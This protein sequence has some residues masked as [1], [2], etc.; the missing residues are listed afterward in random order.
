MPR[1]R[2]G[3][4]GATTLATTLALT[5]VFAGCKDGGT[6]IV[7]APAPAPAPAPAAPTVTAISPSRGP[8]AGGTRVEITGTGL[9]GATSIMIGDAPLANVVVQSATTIVGDTASTRTVSKVMVEVTT[10]NGVGSLADAFEYRLGLTARP[11]AVVVG[12]PAVAL[13]VGDAD[14]DA[15]PDLFVTSR[16]GRVEVLHGDGAGGIAAVTTVALAGHDTFGL[17][18]GDLDGDGDDD[19]VVTD[20]ANHQVLVVHGDGVGGFALAA[21]V[22]GG[23]SS[24]FLGLVAAAA[25]IVTGCGG[26]SSNSS[27]GGSTSTAAA[28]TSAAPTATTSSAAA[29]TVAALVVDATV[30][31]SGPSDPTWY[32]RTDDPGTPDNEAARDLA[33]AIAAAGNG[34]GEAFVYE[35]LTRGGGLGIIVGGLN[36]ERDGVGRP[37]SGWIVSFAPHVQRTLDLPAIQVDYLDPSAGTGL[38]PLDL[39]LYNASF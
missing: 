17:D 29:P 34:L 6:R 8:I 28:V 21:P 5:C 26:S 11:G 19:L 37:R 39:A 13:V 10:P 24:R 31:P 2:L 30:V 25:V 20:I 4:K 14:G 16:A 18:V 7:T 27:S 32:F 22:I 35:H 33:R 36:H 15:A 9:S 38:P 12:D 3:L 23:V 1:R